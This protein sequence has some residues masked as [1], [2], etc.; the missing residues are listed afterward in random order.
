MTFENLPLYDGETVSEVYRVL[1]E[2][3]G[4]AA[5]QAFLGYQTYLINPFSFDDGETRY[6]SNVEYIN[7]IAHRLYMMASLAYSHHRAHRININTT[8]A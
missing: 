4:F 7:N 3:N 2:E 6:Y 1:G 8:Q 5:Q